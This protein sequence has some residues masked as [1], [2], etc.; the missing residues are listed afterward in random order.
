MIK[1]FH[2]LNYIYN[3][4]D[5]GLDELLW[6]PFVA[7]FRMDIVELIILNSHVAYMLGCD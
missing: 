6:R 1:Q 2:E 3:S 7:N 4:N 5:D